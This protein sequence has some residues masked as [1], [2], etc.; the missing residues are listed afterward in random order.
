M[1]S[2]INIKSNN[3]INNKL[4]KY[5]KNLFTINIIKKIQI[6]AYIY[7]KLY[8]KYKIINK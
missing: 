6:L 7:I 2:Y 8:K 1:L 3:I 5:I 4:K